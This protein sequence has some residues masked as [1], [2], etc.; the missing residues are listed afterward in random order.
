VSALY[1][2]GTLV[3]LLL[4]AAPLLI[5]RWRM[6][7]AWVGVL[8]AI[9]SAATFFFIWHLRYRARLIALERALRQMT[10]IAIRPDRILI[11]M[12]GPLGKASYDVP[13]SRVRSVRVARMDDDRASWMK[14]LEL[15]M[16]DGGSVR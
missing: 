6:I 1:A 7:S 11:E 4:L 3:L 8:F 9:F 12:A 2:T 14:C 15:V 13:R 5:D 16:S 10:V